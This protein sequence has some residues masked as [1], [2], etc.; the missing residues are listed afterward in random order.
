MSKPGHNV[1]QQGGSVGLKADYLK[2]GENHFRVFLYVQP[3][4]LTYDVEARTGDGAVSRAW[5][6]LGEDRKR[7]MV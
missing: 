3:K 7:G 6:L 4:T 5:A 2:L 1:F